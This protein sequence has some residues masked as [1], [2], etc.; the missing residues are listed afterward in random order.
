MTALELPDCGD[1]LIQAA[2]SSIVQ[3]ALEVIANESTPLF[4]ENCRDVLSTFAA[5]TKSSSLL[6]AISVIAIIDKK[7]K[8]LFIVLILF[9]LII[10]KIHTQNS[11]QIK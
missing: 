1:R 10:N 4:C 3:F 9:K 6:H 8:N 7:I 11:L 2:S 5:G